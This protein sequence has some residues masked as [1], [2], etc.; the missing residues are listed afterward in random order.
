[1]W[2]GIDHGFGMTARPIIFETMIVDG[3]HSG[4]QQ[5]Y[6]TEDGARRGHMEVMEL[7]LIG[8]N[9]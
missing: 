3:P 2:L 8:A 1:M 7:L 6:P 9:P 5:R 4:W